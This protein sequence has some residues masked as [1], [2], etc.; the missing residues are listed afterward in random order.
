MIVIYREE[1]FHETRLFGTV[2]KFSVLISVRW[3]PYRGWHSKSLHSNY[4]RGPRT[5]FSSY[6]E[7]RRNRECRLKAS[8]NRGS[9]R[10]SGGVYIFLFWPSK[11]RIEGRLV[12][13]LELFFDA[14]GEMYQRN[15]KGDGGQLN[16]SAWHQSHELFFLLAQ[17]NKKSCFYLRFYTWYVFELNPWLRW[18]S[19]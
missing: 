18:G 7:C 11:F 13:L 8:Q 2:T 10:W 19:L 15:W 9:S 5:F 14:S 6:K 17:V 1:E 4:N 16:M 3:H 12:S